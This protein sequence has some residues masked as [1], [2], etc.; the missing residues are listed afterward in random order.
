MTVKDK[1]TPV[2]D[3]AGCTREEK[4]ERMVA[5][6][7][8]NFEDPAERTPYESAEGGY[9]YI[10]GVTDAREELS[11]AFYKNLHVSEGMINMAVDKI[12]EDGADWVPV[13]HP[14]DYE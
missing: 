1:T 4:I 10:W 3:L 14:S 12:E 6:F 11:D 8:E 9:I 13:P 7:F 2:P 5:W